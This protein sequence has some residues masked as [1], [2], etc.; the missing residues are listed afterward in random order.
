M[1]EQPPVQVQQMTRKSPLRRLLGWPVRRVPRMLRQ[2]LLR[3]MLE[4]L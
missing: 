2:L 3:S 1:L 4:M